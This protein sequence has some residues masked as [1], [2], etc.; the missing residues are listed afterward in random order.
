MFLVVRKENLMTAAMKIHPNRKLSREITTWSKRIYRLLGKKYNKGIQM[1]T[2]R[3]EQSHV[4]NIINLKVARQ[5]LIQCH[6][7]CVMASHE[8]F[9]LT[10][11]FR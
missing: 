9:L 6:G 7:K 4:C 8:Y 11:V 10:P 2:K 3:Q 5:K 1:L